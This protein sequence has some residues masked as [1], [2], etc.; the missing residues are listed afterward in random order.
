[1]EGARLGS[2][3]VHKAFEHEQ[4][5]WLESRVGVSRAKA[6]QDIRQSFETEFMTSSTGRWE[7]EKLRQTL[8]RMDG[9]RAAAGVPM[10]D[11]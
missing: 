4:L 3:P 7:M 2:F 9:A 8:A 6:T 11:A 5:Q 10:R 1:M